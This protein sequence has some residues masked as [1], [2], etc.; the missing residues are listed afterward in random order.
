M[1]TDTRPLDTTAG[2]SIH[3]LIRAHGRGFSDDLRLVIA[4]DCAAARS[5]VVHHLGFPTLGG[6]CPGLAAARRKLRWRLLRFRWTSISI[7]GPRP[8]Q[9]SGETRARVADGTSPNVAL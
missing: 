2:A 7:A 3:D 6:A 9:P 4:G 1:P 5:A 8:A